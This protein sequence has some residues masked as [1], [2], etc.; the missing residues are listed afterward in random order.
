M[1]LISKVRELLKPT[2]KTPEELT[3][4]LEAERLKAELKAMRLGR[5]R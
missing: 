1:G 2:P 4:Q 5:R 3:A